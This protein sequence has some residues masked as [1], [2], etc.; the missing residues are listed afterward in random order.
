M[1]E[2]DPPNLPRVVR[3]SEVVLP[4]A[5]PVLTEAERIIENPAIKFSVSR[6]VL[7]IGVFVA[8]VIFGLISSLGLGV[9]VLPNFTVPVVSVVTTYPGATPE[10]LESRSRAKLKMPSAPSRVW[11]TSPRVP[12]AAFHRWQ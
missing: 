1:N 10:D 9:D 5:K 2:N 6:Y 3:G 12:R 8:V 7:S 11:P 4:K